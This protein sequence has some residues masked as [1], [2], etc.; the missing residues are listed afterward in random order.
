MRHIGFSNHTPLSEI[1]V[2][3]TDMSPSIFSP[4]RE[5]FVSYSGNQQ[6][7]TSSASSAAKFLNIDFPSPIV[8]HNQQ[9]RHMHQLAHQHHQLPPPVH[10]NQQFPETVVGK[11]VDTPMSGLDVLATASAQKVDR[12]SALGAAAA[13]GRVSVTSL[14]DMFAPGAASSTDDIIACGT[15]EHDH[16]QDQ[17]KGATGLSFVTT[18]L[19]LNPKPQSAAKTPKSILKKRRADTDGEEQCGIAGGVVGA[20]NGD[21]HGNIHHSFDDSTSTSVSGDR[22][23][24]ISFY[25]PSM[26]RDDGHSAKKRQ[27]IFNDSSSCLLAEDEAESSFEEDSMNCNSLNFNKRSVFDKGRGGG[28]GGDCMDGDEDVDDSMSL[29]NRLFDTSSSSSSGVGSSHDVFPAGDEQESGGYD[30]KRA[31]SSQPVY[32]ASPLSANIDT[33]HRKFEQQYANPSSAHTFLNQLL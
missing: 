30:H 24:S 29:H 27:H 18:N 26:C 2:D 19:D 17:D 20:G 25:S 3:M 10:Q 32:F 8:V 4:S 9:Q 33:R 13:P 21:C 16:D 14:M 28:G 23:T 11:E 5:G 7:A 15:E 22:S 12:A 1:S 6:H 31:M